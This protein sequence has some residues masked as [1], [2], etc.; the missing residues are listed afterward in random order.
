M[1][2]FRFSEIHLSHERT[3]EQKTNQIKSW[4]VKKKVERAEKIRATHKLLHATKIKISEFK[5][6]ENA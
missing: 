3:K 4:K 1:S 5:T 6:Q 2:V